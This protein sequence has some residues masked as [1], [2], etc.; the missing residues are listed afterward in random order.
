MAVL[1]PLWKTDPVQYLVLWKFPQLAAF[2]NV[3]A[4]QRNL[5]TIEQRQK[6]AEEAEAFREQLQAMPDDDIDA[7]IATARADEARRYQEYRE[8]E[9]RNRIWGQSAAEADYRHSATLSYWT[10][11]EVTALSFGKDPRVVTWKAVSPYV[12]IS[13]FAK[14]FAARREIVYRAGTMGQLAQQTQPSMVIAWATRMRVPMPA[15]LVAEVENLGVQIAD[16]KTL[17]DAQKELTE[18]ERTRADENHSAYLAAM[19]DRSQSI[20]KMQ[21]DYV[22]LLAQ[23]DELIALQDDRIKW[24]ASRVAELE[25]SRAPANAAEKPLGTRERESLLKLVLCMA[26]DAYGFDPKASRSPIAKELTGHLALAGLSLDEDTVRK[27][28]AEAKELLP[29]DETERTR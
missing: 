28:L 23:K 17:F 12:H 8:D 3:A 21:D 7:L 24:L 29:G 11:D 14:A 4:R 5:L 2:D 16:W 19:K 25:T 10:L 6:L 18:R 27:Y 1:N 26:M 13:P 20:S 15:E 9:E 22:G